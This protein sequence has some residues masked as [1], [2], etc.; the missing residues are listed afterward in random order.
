[1]I[2]KFLIW[3]KN[4]LPIALLLKLLKSTN[5]PGYP[6]IS[7]FDIA[8]YFIK[9]LQNANLSLRADAIS[10][11][12]F[13]AL[14]PAIIFLFTLIA[15]L[16]IE[17]IDQ[18]IM[19]GLR[20]VIPSVA[21]EAVEGTIFDIV[22]RQR[23]GLLSIGFLFAMFFSTNGILS[24]LEAFN[25]SLKGKEV[26]KGLKMRL[27]SLMLTFFLVFMIVVAI[28]ILLFTS[29]FITQFFQLEIFGGSLSYFLIQLG[30]WVMFYMIILVTVASL[31]YWGPAT[32]LKISFFSIGSAVTS[33][34]MMILILGFSYVI[35]NFGQYNKIYGSIGALLIVML[36]INLNAFLLLIGF[37]FNIIV[38]RLK[39]IITAKNKLK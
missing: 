30:R 27:V 23:G 25:V 16:P 39:K 7:L 4:F 2:D 1:M 35:S 19:E 14:F 9:G 13:I 32:R 34:L 31:Y 12:F 33:F 20:K 24:I 8:K 26:R 37:E 11:N 28:A 6:E 18:I 29:S 5:I 36:L 21:Y 22:A 17:N 10:F 15:Y 3:F 38:H